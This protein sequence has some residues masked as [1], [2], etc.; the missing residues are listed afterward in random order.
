MLTVSS[1]LFQLCISVSKTCTVSRRYNFHTFDH[2]QYEQLGDCRYVLSEDYVSSAF[3]VEIEF[4]DKD[5]GNVRRRMLVV[6]AGCV[7]VTVDY[8][9]NVQV[10]GIDVELPYTHGNPKSVE[11]WRN[12]TFSERDVYIKT[13]RGVRI[14]WT[15]LDA[16]ELFVPKSFSNDLLGLCGNMNNQRDDDMLTRQFLPGR[17]LKEFMHSWKVDGYRYCKSLQTDPGP[18]P[19]YATLEPGL[20]FEHLSP[21][22][23]P[24]CQGVSKAFLQGARDKCNILRTPE[25]LK[26]HRA[27]SI[28]VYYELCLQ[29]VCSCRSNEPCYCQSLTA[30]TREC[31]RNRIRVGWSDPACSKCNIFFSVIHDLVPMHYERV[32]ILQ[33]KL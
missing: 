2:N 13:D 7:D 11:I 23:L 6:H 5:F 4:E 24:A 22:N 1:S 15:M 30:Y 20:L 29:D 25:F 16:V 32:K 3:S 27:V 28:E 19:V 31:Q 8:E 14:H 21:E 10:A 33:G 18:G 12:T 26:C 9:G 17:S